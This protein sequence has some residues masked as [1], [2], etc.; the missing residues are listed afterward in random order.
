VT[1]LVNVEHGLGSA[2]GFVEL[3]EMAAPPDCSGAPYAKLD[4]GSVVPLRTFLRA[5]LAALLARRP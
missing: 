3:H 1:A 5:E 4:T 2:V